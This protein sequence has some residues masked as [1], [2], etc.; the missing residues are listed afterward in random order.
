[1]QATGKV[2]LLTGAK[3]IGAVVAEALAADGI[4]VALTYHRSNVE[5]DTTVN[6]VRAAGRRAIAIHAD[7]GR[8]E[9]CRRVVETTLRE[10]GRLDIFIAMAGLYEN[11]PFNSLTPEI[12]DAQMN[13]ELRSAFLCAH[14]AVPAM[15]GAGGGRIVFFSDW[16]PTSGRPRYQGMLTYYVAKAGLKA[17]TEAMAL[18]LAGDQILV[19]AIAPGPILA[20]PSTT[21]EEHA[22]VASATPLGRWGGAAEIVK[23]VRFLIQTD[24][25]TGETIRIDGGRH[26]K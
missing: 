18:E 10:L 12:W 22:S 20:P 24:F 5:A 3:R 17:L 16:L 23:A 11:T 21:A 26:L 8:V 13:V 4:D 6:T 2:A 25:V 1:M 14:A 9:G 7:L 15:R 19:N